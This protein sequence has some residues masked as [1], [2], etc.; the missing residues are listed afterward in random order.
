MDDFDEEVAV[1][2]ETSKGLVI[3]SGRSH[4]GILNIVNTIQERSGE[5]VYAVIGGFHLLDADEATI[6]ET[7]D[8]L[9]RA[10]RTA[11]RPVSLHRPQGDRHVLGS[12]MP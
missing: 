3:P 10:G 8:P 4:S 11:D 6:Q 5:K 7:I 9:Q 1:A 12:N 2:V